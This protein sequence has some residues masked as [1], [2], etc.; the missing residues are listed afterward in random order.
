MSTFDP[1]ARTRLQSWTE[2]LQPSHFREMGRHVWVYGVS[3]GGQGDDN[4][5]VITEGVVRD[6]VFALNT[7][8][9]SVD[10]SIV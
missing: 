1:C 4:G 6:K 8:N 10:G 3:N 7:E 5:K 9:P 2:T